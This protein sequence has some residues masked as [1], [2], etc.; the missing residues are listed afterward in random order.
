MLGAIVVGTVAGGVYYTSTSATANEPVVASSF[1][2]GVPGGAEAAVPIEFGVVAPESVVVGVSAVVRP[3]AVITVPAELVGR[4][5]GFGESLDATVVPELTLIE[6][7]AAT[8]LGARPL[9]VRS[10]GVP[11]SGELVLDIPGAPVS[12]TPKARGTARVEL[13]GLAATITVGAAEVP[14]RAVSRSVALGTFSVAADDTVQ[15]PRVLAEPGGEVSAKAL[16][17]LPEGKRVRHRFA[18][19]ITTRLAKVGAE[20][21]LTG[22]FVSTIYTEGELEGRLR[23]Q[24]TVNPADVYLVVFRFMPVTNTIALDQREYATGEA[25]IKIDPVTGLYA[26]VQTRAALYV[27]VSNVLQDGVPLDVGAGCETASPLLLDLAGRVNLGQKHPVSN[28]EGLATIPAFAPCGVKEN[29]APLLS[30]LV[31]GPG[32]KVSVKL[33]YIDV[34]P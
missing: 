12:F 19:E 2:C 22:E 23:G 24:I 20:V 14:C 9:A 17:P 25:D 7:E 15:P 3:R 30:G 11:G 4:L 10:M 18:M 16:P 1:V 28:L 13:T 8:E 27:K 29:V 34:I 21:R 5:R 6:G 32:N 33:T 31:S 26:A